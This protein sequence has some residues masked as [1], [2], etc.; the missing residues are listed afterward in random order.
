MG[1]T[2]GCF[3][4][5][6]K[7]CY[8]VNLK[9]ALIHKVIVAIRFRS[10]LGSCLQKPLY[11]F[12]R[13]TIEKWPLDTSFRPILETWL[14]YIRPWRYAALGGN[15]TRQSAS[16]DDAAPVDFGLW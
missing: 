6:V 15:E 10:L 16:D 12:L 13:H 4:G 14:T 8:L 9:G 7:L 3:V 5:I 1:R 2:T 11:S